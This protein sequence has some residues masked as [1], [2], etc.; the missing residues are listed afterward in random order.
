MRKQRSKRKASGTLERCWG[1]ARIPNAQGIA[2]TQELCYPEFSLPTR[3]AATHPGAKLVLIMFRQKQ[4]KACER[5][6]R[7]SNE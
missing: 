6:V 4:R 5:I 7:G 1:I 3:L 2:R